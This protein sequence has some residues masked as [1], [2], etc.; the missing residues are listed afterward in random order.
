MVPA[1]L[2]AFL[3]T[4]PY[5]R[6]LTEGLFYREKMKAIHRVAPR[7]AVTR[8][9][10][11]GG[12]RS[13]LASRLFPGARVTNLDLDPAYGT[14]RID[15]SPFVAAD[16]TRLPFPD[17]AFDVV[18]LFDVLEHIEAD[19]AAAQEALRV[20]KPGGWVMV[21]SPNEQWRF[22]YHRAFRRICPTDR[23]VMD[24]WGHVRRG[25]ELPELDDLFGRTHVA[26]ATFINPVTVVHHDLAFSNLPTG[27]KRAALCR[28]RTGGV[29]GRV[30]AP[31]RRDGHRDGRCV[32]GREHGDLSGRTG[33]RHPPLG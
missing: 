4:N 29:A 25:Y 28:D 30:A 11:I 26:R 23:E 5:P 1:P 12:G 33:G 6:P 22:P 7:Q 8:V 15:G 16:A 19:R 24:E 2:P 20:L 13:G 9:L 18:T 14:D 31:P 3:R 21:S 10:E 17:G 27:V 32:A